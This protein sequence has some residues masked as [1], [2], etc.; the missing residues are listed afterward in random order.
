MHVPSA[1]PIGAINQFFDV[2]EGVARERFVERRK[3]R[4]PPTLFHRA[5]PFCQLPLIFVVTFAPRRFF[6]AR[7]ARLEL[8]AGNPPAHNIGIYRL[9][10]A[11]WPLSFLFSS[12]AERWKFYDMFMVAV[13]GM[14]RFSRV[15]WA[16]PFFFVWFL[17]GQCRRFFVFN[18]QV[19]MRA[20]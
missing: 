6:F 15:G 17:R 1:A 11:A 16:R 14:Q 20:A 13:H 4:A 19:V 9:S 2:V 10:R 12:P 7:R 18:E 3:E 8:R 5:H